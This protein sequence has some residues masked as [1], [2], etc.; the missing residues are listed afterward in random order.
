MPI[1]DLREQE[2]LK[3]GLALGVARHV[4]LDFHDSG[5]AGEPALGTLVSA[6]L[7][8]VAAAVSCVIDEIDPE[9]IVTLDPHH[10]DGHRDHI[11]IGQAVTAACSNRADIRLYYWTL[12]RPLLSRWFGEL[13]RVRPD[14][15]HIDLDR[16]GLGRCDEDTTTLLDTRRVR[17]RRERAIAAHASQV[18]PFEGM[19]ADLRSAF[20]TTDRLVRVQPAWTGGPL[21][22]SLF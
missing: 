8:Q 10:G 7:E 3:A 22:R 5:M 13:A 12:S 14:S 15:E 16:S 21:E 19:P 9:I 6:G 11:V 2:L 1:R 20:L 4:I 18:S 17:G